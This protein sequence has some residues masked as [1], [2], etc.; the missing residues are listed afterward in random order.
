MG[1]FDGGQVHF[2]V[3]GDFWLNDSVYVE[4]YEVDPY[5]GQCGVCRLDAGYKTHAYHY[6]VTDDPG[7]RQGHVFRSTAQPACWYHYQDHSGI[8]NM[9]TPPQNPMLTGTVCVVKG[10]VD[11]GDPIPH[12]EDDP[13]VEISYGVAPAETILPAEPDAIVVEVYYPGYE[14]FKKRWE[15]SGGQ[16]LSGSFYWDGLLDLYD[17]YGNLVAS[18]V[19]YCPCSTVFARITV[20]VKDRYWTIYGIQEPIREWT[21]EMPAIAIIAPPYDSHYTTG[22]AVGFAVVKS[23]AIADPL[24]GAVWSGGESPATGAGATFSTSYSLPSFYTVSATLNGAYGCYQTSTRVCVYRIRLADVSF[25]GNGYHM[26]VRDT[27]SQTGYAPPH[28]TPSHEYPVSYRRNAKM[29]VTTR[30]SVEP[31]GAFTD[32][33]TAQGNNAWGLN[34]PETTATVNGTTVTYSGDCTT[35]FPNAI[36]LYDPLVIYWWLYTYPLG[37]TFT[38]GSENPCYLTLADPIGTPFHTLLYIG[39]SNAAGLTETTPTAE[40]IWTEFTDLVVLRRDAP[41]TLTYWAD[42]SASA[43]ETGR[44]LKDGNGQ[45]GAWAE[46]LRDSWRVQAITSGRKLEVLP[47]IVDAMGFLVKDWNFIDPGSS[48]GTYPFVFVEDVDLFDD[49][50]GAPG[51]GNQNPPGAFM[52]H[53]IVRHNEQYYDPSYGSGP[54]SSDL[55]W[56]NA[57]LDG[58]WTVGD[59]YGEKRLFAKRKNPYTTETRFEPAD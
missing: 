38:G 31:A 17:G 49:P 6:G 19:G 58:L 29:H 16:G 5:T 23:A 26:V 39:C 37:W 43:T 7:F 20:K 46:C 2:A 1:C 15:F 27:G 42:D 14:N 13:A 33:F 8:P 59:W 55:N 57:S 53:F 24:S 34:F 44:L 9:L 47:N 36:S 3:G 52:N 28:W 48:P 25:S 41:T 10:S 32:I 30:W 54:F 45:C 35:S 18:N 50:S 21:W 11:V 12:Q 4:S 22:T 56:E 40:A 51:Q